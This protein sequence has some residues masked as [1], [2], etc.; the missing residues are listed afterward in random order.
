MGEEEKMFTNKQ[1][2]VLKEI[3]LIWIPA[4]GTLYFTLA[5]IWG[6]PYGEQIVGTLTAID[7]FIGAVLKIS[8]VKYYNDLSEI[9]FEEVNDDGE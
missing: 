2:D 7:A 6:F 3:A 4:I 8:T 9:G 5:G 1:Y